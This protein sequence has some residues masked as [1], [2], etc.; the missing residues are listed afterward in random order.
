MAGRDQERAG[1]SRNGCWTCRDKK[2][3]CDEARPECQRCTRLALHCDYSYRPR[4]RYTRRHPPKAQAQAAA[5]D[6]R[7]ATASASIDPVTPSTTQ[8]QEPAPVEHAA[9]ATPVP[10]HT[11]PPTPRD[12]DGGHIETDCSYDPLLVEGLSPSCLSIVGPAEREAIDCYRTVIGGTVDS[13]DAQYSMPT[14]IWGIAKSRP[15]VLHMICAL[16]SL[17]LSYQAT[18]QTEELGHQLRVA[19]ARHYGTSMRLLAHAIHD[20][21]ESSLLDATLATLWLMIIYE[22]KFG[23]GWGEGLNTHLIGAASVLRSRL[24][25]LKTLHALPD[26]DEEFITRSSF[27]DQSPVNRWGISPFSGRLIVWISFLDA[28]AAFFGFGGDFNQSLGEVMGGLAEDPTV[29]RLRGFACIHR[30]SAL[31][32]STIWGAAY[33][34]EQ[35]L[36]DL[37]NRESFYFYGQ[38][39]QLRFIISQL[40][41]AHRAQDDEATFGDLAQNAARALRVVGEKY[42]ELVEV[43]PRLDF[44]SATG[45]EKRFISNLRF[46]I[47]YYH[48]VVTCYFRITRRHS[49][50]ETGQL[51]ALQQI[52]VLAYRAYADE[53]DDAMARIAWPLF[54]A[55]LETTDLVHRDWILTRFSRLRQRGENYRRAYA[56]LLRASQ[57]EDADGV[58][59]Q[60]YLDVL[61]ESNIDKFV[62]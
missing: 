17:Q 43:A 53:G 11:L 55:A 35:L 61:A 39:G 36:E 47:P 14:I 5:D 44:R 45:R 25:N 57:A 62:I 18:S 20:T 37:E 42:S 48:A 23:D 16:G 26:R 50:P 28:G 10:W 46:I 9:P 3:K 6:T 4:K 34:Q 30:Y 1:R 54:I 51:D 22:Q 59:R 40:A 38:I 56:V 7:S 31:T 32:S 33:P 19:G 2:V 12:G 52:M 27:L 49:P 8:G 13:K 29:S 41:A 21:S 60:S 15:M 24:G 58:P